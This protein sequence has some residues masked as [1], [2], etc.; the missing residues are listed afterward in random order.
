MMTNRS[1]YDACNNVK[2][3]TQIQWIC[4]LTYAHMYI[5]I[6]LKQTHINT[7]IYKDIWYLQSLKPWKEKK[8]KKISST[9]LFSIITKTTTIKFTFSI[10][11]NCYKLW[12]YI[13]TDTHTQNG[14]SVFQ[15]V[16]RELD[17]ESAHWWGW[18]TPAEK[19]LSKKQ[20]RKAL[21]IDSQC[22]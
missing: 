12:N 2:A 7:A 22:G 6:Y 9:I 14:Q 19:L 18:W 16:R 11:S 4:I 13:Y 17:T 20:R 21:N 1:T 15:A 8:E 3:H 10:S 5:L